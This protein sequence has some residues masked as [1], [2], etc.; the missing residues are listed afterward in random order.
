[1]NPRPS[2]HCFPSYRNRTWAAAVLKRS[3]WFVQAA[4]TDLSNLGSVTTI[5][6]W[7]CPQSGHGIPDDFRK[8]YSPIT[9]SV[10][11]VSSLVD[12]SLPG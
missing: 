3:A 2:P 9:G 1:M 7:N 5:A 10:G 12:L 6:V 11:A 4:S 8:S